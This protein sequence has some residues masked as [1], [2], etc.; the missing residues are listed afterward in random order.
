MGQEL[1]GPAPQPLATILLEHDAASDELFAAG[2]LGGEM[3]NQFFA[4]HE[5][6]L[7]LENGSAVKRGAS[8]AAVVIELEQYGRQQVKC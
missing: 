3:F 4:K 6:K 8:G 7:A 2:T 5:L 1:S